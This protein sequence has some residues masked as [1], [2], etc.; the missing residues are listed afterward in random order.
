MPII[1]F[2]LVENAF[3]DVQLGRLL[4][5]GSHMLAEVL[6]TPVERTRAFVTLYRPDRTAVAGV[7]VN[8]GDRGAPFFVFY[9]GAHRRAELR[10]ALL[11]R[12]TDLIE[13]T[14]GVE[15]AVIR[16]YAQT[17]DPD[18]WAVAGVPLSRARAAEVQTATRGHER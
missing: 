7:V 14:L 15:R 11:T 6:D 9:V 5:D 8:D 3:S 10:T 2:H 4:T 1:T 17:T 13:T 12:V 18:S 16:G